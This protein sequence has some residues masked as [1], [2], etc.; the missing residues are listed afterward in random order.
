MQI[1]AFL[2]FVCVLSLAL[3]VIAATVI[4][5]KARIVM[6]LRGDGLPE[7]RFPAPQFKTANVL[8]FRRSVR[9]SSPQ[10]APLPLAA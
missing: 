7:A 1:V 5:S 3:G 6:A 2:F 10:P 9:P 4:G 8:A